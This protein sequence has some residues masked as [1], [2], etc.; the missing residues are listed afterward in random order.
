MRI[1]LAFLVMGWVVNLIFALAA[2]DPL[3]IT[4]GVIYLGACA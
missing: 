4:F 3:G 1:L 2:H